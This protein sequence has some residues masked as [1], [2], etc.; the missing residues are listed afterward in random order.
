[1]TTVWDGKGLPPAAMARMARGQGSRLRSSLMPISSNAAV[2]GCGFRPVGE[3]MGC[4]VEQIGWQ[5]WQGCGY[6]N[7]GGYGTIGGYGGLA[8]TGP[9][10]YGAYGDVSIGSFSGFAPYVDALYRGWDT[11]IYRMLLECQALGGDG[12]V[13]VRLS[14]AAPRPV[15]P[16]IHGDRHRRAL[17]RADAAG[18]ALYDDP[19]RAGLREARSTPAGCRAPILVGISVAIRHDD[20]RTRTEARAWTT[21]TEVSGYSELVTHV[22]ADVRAKLAQ[23]L[24]RTSARTAPSPRR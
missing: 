1:M 22:R 6:G 21:N 15:Q 19:P 9:G 7:Y 8:S 17:E 13:D 11:A 4:I 12:V 20:Y 18:E 2:E 3:V 14:R 24:D 23:R 5:G 16:G 10:R